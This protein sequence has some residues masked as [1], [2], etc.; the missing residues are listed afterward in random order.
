MAT[1]SEHIAPGAAVENYLKLIYRLG[2]EQPH[3]SMAQVAEGMGVSAPAVTKMVKRLRVEGMVTYDRGSGLALTGSGRRTALN[4]LRSHRLIELFLHKHLGY[5]WDEVH[6]EAEQ[7]EHVISDRFRNRIAKLMGNPTHD[8][9]GDPIPTADGTIEPRAEQSL[10]AVSVGFTGSIARVSS[11]D[12]EM[13]RYMDSQGLR[14]GVEVKV[15]SVEP[16]GGPI[17][18]VIKGKEK[19]IGRELAENVFFA[20]T[21]KQK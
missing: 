10:S 20:D 7:L 5:S 12:A 1:T 4:V 18:I 19:A 11:L 17:N 6:E 2:R 21:E 9:H 16:Y 14:P 3:V 15:K 13:L 8:P